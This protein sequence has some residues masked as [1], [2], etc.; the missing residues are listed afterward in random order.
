MFLA[1]SVSRAWIVMAYSLA[2][3]RRI[4][5]AGSE[6]ETPLLVPSFSSK[7][8]GPI[9][10]VERRRREPK[11]DELV[12]AS[13]IH[14]EAFVPGI[15]EA[16]LI[17]AYDIHHQLLHDADSLSSGFS[18]SAY[19]APNVLFVDSGWY[20]LS[21]G[22]TS[23]QWYHEVGPQLEFNESQYEDV[24]ASLDSDV[25]AVVVG[26]D[27]EG[28]YEK[29]ID[30]AQKFFAK[31]SRFDSDVLLKPTGEK[32]HHDFGE[33]TTVTAKRLRAF[34]VVGVT[35]KELGNTMLQRLR[36]LAFLRFRLLEADVTIPIHVFGGLEPLVTPL[37]F[38][39]G[40]E[41]FDGLAWLRYA[42]VDGMS[43]NRESVVLLEKT[44][45]NRFGAAI[46]H[47]QLKNLD[48]IAELSRELKVFF[49]NACDWTK[50]RNGDLLRP[51]FEA[52]ESGLGGM[53]GR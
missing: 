16:I 41:I 48:A 12:P 4:Q 22:P 11:K 19:A 53:S 35:E 2:R 13:S 46:S 33:L 38:A 50:L 45:D 42:F 14:T 9:Q 47:L 30:A 51:A 40:A 26:W 29:Q 39:A 34:D 23:G 52:L 10:L 3:S 1:T 28:S 32:M 15:A 20:E 44:Y 27:S 31:H 8:L 25:E 17:S 43:I 6:V 5:L 21:I 49:H 18:D 37:Y 7:A 24:I 36:Q